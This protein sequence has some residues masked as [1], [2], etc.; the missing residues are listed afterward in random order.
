MAI[1]GDALSGRRKYD[2]GSQMRLAFAQVFATLRRRVD[3]VGGVLDATEREQ[4]GRVYI[5]PDRGIYEGLDA[6]VVAQ[7]GCTS[8]FSFRRARV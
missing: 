4:L 1:G 6:D 7:M 2:A 8:Y 5:L 3:S